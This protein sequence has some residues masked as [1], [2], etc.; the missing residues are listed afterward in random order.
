MFG[1]GVSAAKAD[2]IESVSETFASG[3]TFNGKV[4]F[5]DGF[6]TAVAV[7]GVL[8]GGGYGTDAVNWVW[9]SWNYAG[10]SIYE[11]FLIDGSPSDYNY[12]I[13]FT[14]DTSDAPALAF[15]DAGFGNSINFGADPLVSGTIGRDPSTGGSIAV[16]P[17]PTSLAILGLGLAGLG[18]IRRRRNSAT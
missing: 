1:L 5:D 10:G 4:T 18:A 17:E 7:N 2:V 8:S 11:N 14:V 3:A 16:V 9:D 6:S 12:F 13:S 15:S